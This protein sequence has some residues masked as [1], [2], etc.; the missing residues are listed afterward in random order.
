MILRG[1]VHLL[2][3]MVV[4]VGGVVEEEDG[5]QRGVVVVL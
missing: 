5:F 4:H 2:F 3:E 1:R